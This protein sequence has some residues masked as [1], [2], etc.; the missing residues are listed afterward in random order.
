MRET[1]YLRLGAGPDADV[2]FGVAAADFRSLVV[3][4]APIS[5]ALQLAA[6]RRLIVLVPGADVRLAS[7]KVPAKQPAKILQALP[8]VLEDQVADDVE[9][10]H[11]AIGPRLADGSHPVAIVARQRIDAWLAPLRALGLRPDMVVPDTLALPVATDETSWSALAEAD[12]VIVRN[13][14]WS[15]FSCNAGDLV[16]YLSI[17][18]AD[19]THTLRLL[20]AGDSTADWSQLDWPVTLLP[21]HASGLSALAAHLKAEHSI[22]LLQGSYSQGQDLQKLWK[23]WRLAAVLAVLWVVIAG[24]GYSLDTW[25]LS[26]ELN[27]QDEA[28]IARFQQL[29]PDQTRVV[30]LSTQLDQQLLILAGGGGANGPLPLLEVFTQAMQASPGLK[31]TGMQ[32]R[33]NALF[34]SLTATD[35][36]VLEAL[37]NWFS[38]Q[39]GGASLEVQSANA[40]GEGVQIRAKLNPA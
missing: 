5:A 12:Q 17:D 21:G 7:A 18:D 10:L 27:R 1:L 9:T 38:S 30:D 20:V 13:G 8:Y 6:G 33:E 26:S 2:E 35:L 39:S 34:L 4:R 16:P 19:K 23:P 14:A 32:F 25:S 40:E 24:A 22:N 11:F 3:Q 29:F 31:I 15:G 37:Q 28:N 36:Q